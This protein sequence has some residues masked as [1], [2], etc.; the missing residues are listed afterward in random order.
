MLV[1]IPC[2]VLKL[3]ELLLFRSC[4]SH[5]ECWKVLFLG[6]TPKRGVLSFKVP[7]SIEVCGSVRSENR[8][9]FTVWAMCGYSY[10]IS[11]KN[12]FSK[13]FSTLPLSISLAVVLATS[14]KK[15]FSNKGIKIAYS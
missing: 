8:H 1:P 9:S 11:L 6:L 15:P 10:W 7:S 5:K 2:K 13:P 4:S 12:S 3:A 14:A